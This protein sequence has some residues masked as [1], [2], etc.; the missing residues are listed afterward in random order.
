MSTEPKNLSGKQISALRIQA[1]KDWMA[2][3]SDQDYLSIRHGGQLKREDIK[4]QC[5]E[6][7]SDER[8]DFSLQCLTKN[9][10]IEELL[11]KLETRLWED[12]IL[13]IKPVLGI[14]KRQKKKQEQ[15]PIIAKGSISQKE[16]AKLTQRILELESENEALKGNYGRFSEVAEV[17]QRLSEMKS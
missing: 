6:L 4:T 7:I 13:T 16:A 9:K 17:Y 12:K 14:K 3:M 11:F 2:S 5:D 15:K 8:C 10:N 1:F